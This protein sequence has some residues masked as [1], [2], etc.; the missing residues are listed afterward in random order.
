MFFKVSQVK[1]KMCVSYWS[2]L[3]LFQAV[4][5]NL[6]HNEHNPIV[7]GTTA[8]LKKYIVPVKSVDTPT[9]SRVF[10]NFYTFLHCRIIVKTSKL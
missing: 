10:L 9:H 8:V 2:S 6:E 4:F 5:F 1:L 3:S 7:K